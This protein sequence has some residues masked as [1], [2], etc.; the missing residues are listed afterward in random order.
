M[1]R[2]W[3]IWLVYGVGLAALMGAF[4]WLTVK[5]IELDRAERLA[6]RQAE[7]EEDISRAL[8]RMDA[9]LT[10]LLAEEAARPEFIYRSINPVQSSAKGM[11]K[12]AKEATQQELSPV[13]AAPPDYVLLHFEI[14]PDGRVTS[15][16]CPTG[17][18][19]AWSL[20]L[21]LPKSIELVSTFTSTVPASLS[22]T[23]VPEELLNLPRQVDSPPK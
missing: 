9:L 11:G 19:L 22:S 12:D 7:L 20:S 18:D 15:P 21:S 8:W 23:T 17:S 2:P 16:Q 10:P 14:H 6:R 4:A 5:A 1:K 3:Q 13:L